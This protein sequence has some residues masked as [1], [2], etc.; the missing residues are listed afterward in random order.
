[1]LLPYTTLSLSV[2]QQAVAVPGNNGNNDWMIEAS[3]PQIRYVID[4]WVIIVEHFG[5]ERT[6]PGNRDDQQQ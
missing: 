6:R 1:M 4:T 5:C 3:L 2:P